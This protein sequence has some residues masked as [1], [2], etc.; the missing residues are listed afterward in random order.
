VRHL[1]RIL[2]GSFVLSIRAYQRLFMDFHVWGREQIPEGPK[3]YV[4]NHITSTDLYW[5]LP[6]FPE[7]VHF[8]LGPSYQFRW[9]GRF[10][11][12]FEMISAMPGEAK[13]LIES[14]V[15]Y[16][17]KGEPVAI[18]AEGDIQ[19]PFRV[20][21]LQP[22]VAAIYRRAK[23]PI[24]PMA[25][26]APQRC[27]RE[28]P[29]P[30]VID[31]RVYRTV[32]ALRGPFGVNFGEPCLPD[33]PQGSRKEQNDYLLNFLRERLQSLAEDARAHKFWL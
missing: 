31:G 6:A 10:L 7:P 11:D 18:A 15:R 27:L 20:G 5:T 3:I 22:G 30:Q 24:V 25:L 12:T 19:D 4:S 32:A 26:I 17:E 1:P 2:Y 13:T 28:Y 8:V 9:W 23:V 29:F 14:S 33:L 21:P 16:L